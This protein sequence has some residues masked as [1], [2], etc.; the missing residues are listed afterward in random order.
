MLVNVSITQTHPYD[1]LLIKRPE[2]LFI[3]TQDAQYLK[4][5]IGII[6]IAVRL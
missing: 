1:V 6:I 4:K 5:A 2:Y 3:F